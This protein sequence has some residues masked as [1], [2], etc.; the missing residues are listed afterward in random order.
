[1]AWLARHGVLIKGGAA[2]ERLAACDTFAF[3]KTGTLTL[4]RP[5]L[6]GRIALEPWDAGRIA[7]ARRDRRDGRASTRSPA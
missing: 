1:M 5:E 7:A 3:D 6:A 4:G 2:L